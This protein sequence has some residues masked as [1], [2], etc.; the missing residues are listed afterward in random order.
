MKKHILTVSTAWWWVGVVGASALL[1]LLVKWAW[2]TFFYSVLGFH[3]V[4]WGQTLA[5]CFWLVLIS[6]LVVGWKE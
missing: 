5:L 2:N 3:P 6:S 4:D 1:V